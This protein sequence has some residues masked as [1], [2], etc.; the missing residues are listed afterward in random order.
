MVTCCKEHRLPFPMLSIYRFRYRFN[1]SE[2]QFQQVQSG[3]DHA[4]I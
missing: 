3:K 4:G 2:G 1:P